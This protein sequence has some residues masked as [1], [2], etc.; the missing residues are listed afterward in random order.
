MAKLQIKSEKIIPFGGIFFVLD[1]FD[2]ILSSVIDSHL[3]L[4]SKLIGYQYSEI[5]RAV[6]SVFYCGGDCM[7]D[8]NLYRH[9]GKLLP[10]HRGIA[11][12]GCPLWNQGHRQSQEF[13][14]QIHR[15]PCQVDQNGTTIQTQHLLQQTIQHNLGARID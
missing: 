9:G 5:I 15:R 10:I 4:R 13:S 2:S 6:F 12:Y 7:E 8:L 14:V 11:A 1:K 3:G